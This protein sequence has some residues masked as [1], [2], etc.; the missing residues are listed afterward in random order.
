MHDYWQKQL[1]GTP[2]FPDILWS[3]PETTHGAG[4]LSIIGGNA[5][6]F[7]APG[8]AY[9]TSLESGVGIVRVLLP[10]AVRKV[11]HGLLPDA[12]FAP[13]TPSGSFAKSALQETLSVAHWADCCLLA[14]D[15]GR[16]SETAIFLERFIQK[17]TGLLTITQDAIEYFRETPLQLV[18]RPDTLIVLSLSQLQ[19]YF[20]N[21]PTITPITYSMSTLQL[22][23]ALH[24]YTN[25]HPVC[26][27][28][29]HN[30]I[31]FMARSGL[32]ITQKYDYKLWRVITAARASVFWLQ[33][34][35]KLLEAIVSSVAKNG[36]ED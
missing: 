29:K 4:K 36:S 31:L 1:D 23:E 11:V 5:H 14:G 18:D 7:G 30:N 20:I 35:G 26:I 28:T 2:L 22:V 19:K 3:R 33:N 10:D 15:F 9:G 6:G 12:D 16:N 17:Y 21:T 27:I 25:Q 32:V 13:S 24:E 34:P 8:N